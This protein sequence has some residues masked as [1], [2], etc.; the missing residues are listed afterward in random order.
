[1]SDDWYGHRN[2]FG[3]PVG[4]KDEWIVWDYALVNAFQ[5]IEDWTDQHGLLRYEVDDPHERTQVLA[6]KR[7]DKFEA[8][9]TAIT[10]GQKNPP[11]GQYFVPKIEL[12]PGVEEW[13]TMREFIEAEIEKEKMLEEEGPSEPPGDTFAQ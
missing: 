8:Q 9:K 1:M 5:V 6:M 3:E 11:P 4:D 13:P 12:L 2:E 7:I 10:K